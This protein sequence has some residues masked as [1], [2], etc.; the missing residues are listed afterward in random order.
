MIHKIVFTVGLTAL[1]LSGVSGQIIDSTPHSIQFV[2]VENNVKLEVLDWGGSGRPVVLLAGLGDT[3]HA[4]DKFAPKL[5]A[6]CGSCH[7]YGITRRGFGSSSAP[8]EIS[9]GTYAAD[10]L[11]DDVLT[12]VDA[13]QLNRPPVLVGHSIAG[14]ELSSVGSRHS[15]KVAGLVYLD[16][17]YGYAFYDSSLGDLYLDL[18]DLEKKLE[19]LRPGKGPNDTRSIVQE[20]RGTLLPKFEKD[21]NREHAFLQTLSPE[22]LA[23]SSTRM[24]VSSQAVISG[25][26][27]YTEIN[28]PVLAIFAIPH[29]MGLRGDPAEVTAAEAEDEI[30]SGAQVKAFEVGIPS[31]RVVRL[32][33]ANHY[34]YRSNEAEVLREINTFIAGVR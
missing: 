26:Q 22:M 20:L 5:I 8:A 17:G 12:V 24:P 23:G 14:E 21:L 29:D 15:E 10:R 1:F 25:E 31:A 4:F 9:D 34:V 3:A 18:F 30:S 27:K 2:P 11:G 16:A 7:V 33:R 19:L 32:P 28:A 6:S 13:L